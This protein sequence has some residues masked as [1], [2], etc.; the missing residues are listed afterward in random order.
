MEEQARCKKC[1][2]VLRSPASIARGMGSTCAGTAPPFGKGFSFR[3]RRG[4]AKPYST[5]GPNRIQNAASYGDL[6]TKPTSQRERFRRAKEE[7]RELFE[8]RM[9]FQCGVVAKTTIPVIYVPLGE[10][11]WK[12]NHSGRIIAHEKLQAYLKRFSLI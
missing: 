3:I 8:Q 6:S 1:G 4:S 2:R 9:P 10:S 7:R 12:E 5:P 11:V